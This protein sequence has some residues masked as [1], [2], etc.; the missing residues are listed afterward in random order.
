MNILEIIGFI[1]SELVGIIFL[2]W[3]A[4]FLRVGKIEVTKEEDE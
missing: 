1:T 3:A 2:L 4:G